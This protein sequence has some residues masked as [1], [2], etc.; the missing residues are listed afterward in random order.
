MGKFIG[1]IIKNLTSFFNSGN[2]MLL[3][4]HIKLRGFLYLQA[5]R[6]LYFLSE[7]KTI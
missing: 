7:R 1:K 2:I 4:N 6:G 3:T 5:K